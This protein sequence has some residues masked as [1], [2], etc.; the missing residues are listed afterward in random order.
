MQDKL[1]KRSFASVPGLDSP[2]RLI[3][4]IARP[5]QASRLQAAAADPATPA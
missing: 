5:P 2:A 1:Y 3:R 4:E